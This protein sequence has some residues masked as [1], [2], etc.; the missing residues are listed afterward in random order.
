MH[1]NETHKSREKAEPILLSANQIAAIKN[2][3]NTYTGRHDKLLVCLVLDHGLRVDELALLKRSDF[4]LEGG[5]VTF[6]RPRKGQRETHNLTD[7]T[8]E[9]AR[10]YFATDATGYGNIWRTNGKGRSSLSEHGLSPRDLMKRVRSL[11][12]NIGIENL[13]PYDLRHTWRQTVHM[14]H[15]WVQ[16][17]TNI[18]NGLLVLTPKRQMQ[19]L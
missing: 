2:Q 1:E 17:T 13:S 15:F 6:D 12:K 9:A 14:Q 16:T 8:L 10:N 5:T 18:F 3:P 19:N 11:G 4:S 7:E